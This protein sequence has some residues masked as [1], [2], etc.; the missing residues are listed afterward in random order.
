MKA[1]GFRGIIA[2]VR[3]R[4][5]D[6][7]GHID[8]VSPGGGVCRDSFSNVLAYAHWYITR[9]AADAPSACFKRPEVAHGEGRG[10]SSSRL[11]LKVET[12]QKVCR[13]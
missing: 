3:A 5:R 1:S 9:F 4:F 10:G 12:L 2:V 11:E 13:D 6:V 7:V 8:D